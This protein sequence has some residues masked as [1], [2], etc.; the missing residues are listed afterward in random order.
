MG[1]VS[2]LGE[3]ANARPWLQLGEQL[4]IGGKTTFGLG[5]YTVIA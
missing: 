3:I 5:H 4:H 2:Y 1:Q